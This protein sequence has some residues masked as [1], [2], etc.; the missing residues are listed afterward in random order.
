MECH[1]FYNAKDLLSKIV[2]HTFLVLTKRLLSGI[3]QAIDTNDVEIKS[4]PTRTSGFFGVEM[5]ILVRVQVLKCLIK[6]LNSHRDMYTYMCSVT[7]I[8]K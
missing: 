8:C 6:K 7:V 2:L 3:F 5:N 1:V 4:L